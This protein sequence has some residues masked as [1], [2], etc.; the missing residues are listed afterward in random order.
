MTCV[1]Q[2]EIICVV[3]FVWPKI[4]NRQIKGMLQKH[5]TLNFCRNWVHMPGGHTQICMWEV[6]LCVHEGKTKNPF[7]W[8]SIW[9]QPAKH[10]QAIVT[11]ESWNSFWREQITLSLGPS[12][13]ES[14]CFCTCELS[15]NTF[16]YLNKDISFTFSQSSFKNRERI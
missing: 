10:F 12:Y 14:L 6:C 2:G 3:K 5:V 15:F 1:N 13:C 4:K 8:T 16:S 11:K 9:A 7:G